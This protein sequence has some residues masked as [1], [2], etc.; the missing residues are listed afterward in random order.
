VSKKTYL[1]EVQYLLPIYKHMK[2]KA[3]SPEAAAMTAVLTADDGEGW[4]NAK[5]D[6]DSARATEATM[7]WP[8]ANE[9]YEVDPLWTAPDQPS[10]ETLMAL[11]MRCPDSLNPTL[12]VDLI[13]DIRAV[14]ETRP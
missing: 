1:V 12:D 14:I 8:G 7:V 5:E 9:A 4:E 3:D 11:L 13:R 2:V 10:V 6:H